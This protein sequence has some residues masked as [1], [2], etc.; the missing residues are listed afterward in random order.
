[1]FE[2]NPP[3]RKFD[4]PL[5]IAQLVPSQLSKSLLNISKPAHQL[6]SP[7]LSYKTARLTPKHSQETTPIDETR[8]YASPHPLYTLC[9]YC[10][11]NDIDGAFELFRG[12]VR[13]YE[14]KL[15]FTLDSLGGMGYDCANQNELP[16]VEGN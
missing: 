16:I 10:L 14:L 15:E 1:M 6:Q 13:L 11:P 7:N 9:S 4:T 5:L 8:P 3:A 12:A 2:A